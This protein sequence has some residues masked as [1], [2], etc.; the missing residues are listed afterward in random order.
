MRL[1]ILLLFVSN[2][3]IGQS[4]DTARVMQYNIL[5]YG[6]NSGGCSNSSAA[7]AIQDAAFKKIAHSTKPDILGINEM[8]N[9]S[10]YADRIL[11]N[12]LNTNGVNYYQR[13][14]Y[15][16]TAGSEI[17]NMF[18]Y[19]SQKFGIASEEIINGVLRDINLAR[20]YYKD[21]LL[22]QGADT[23]FLTIINAHLKAGSTGSDQ[24][25][26]DQQTQ[27]IINTLVSKGVRDNYL[28]MGDFNSRS[29]NEA[30]IQ[31]LLNPSDPKVKFID[32]INSLGFWNNNSSFAPIHTQ[33]TYTSSGCGAGGGMDDRFDVIFAS[34]YIMG[35][36]A[37][38]EYIPGT[39]TAYGQDGNRFNSSI[40]AGTN[41]AVP[42]S[43]ADALFD[44]SDHLPVYLD[45]EIESTG[46]VALSKSTIKDEVKLSSNPIDNEIK[47]SFLSRKNYSIQINTI[48][49]KIIGDYRINDA[50]TL[51][52]PFNEESGI[53]IL[54]WISEDGNCGKIKILKK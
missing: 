7:M 14:Q 34:E 52:L 19:N 49:G 4:I 39:Y 12:V 35:D 41:S 8:A 46:M 10:L 37:N 54:S 50:Q 17:V 20:F 28:V 48:Q 3:S 47:L 22:A 38:I 45:L 16:N 6:S 9:N 2:I 23:V 43:I 13:G 29:S 31:N 42:D 30:G 15:S 32:P 21:P 27:N 33:S 44:L 18:F 40:N 1:I 36:S 24:N 53:Y 51:A 25:T 26:R 5:F 11:Q